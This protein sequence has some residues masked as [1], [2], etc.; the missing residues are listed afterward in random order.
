M[1]QIDL[2]ETLRIFRNMKPGGK[3]ESFHRALRHFL[4]DRVDNKRWIYYPHQESR[5]AAIR[6]EL[7]TQR[8]KYGAEI[9]EDR[10]KAQRP[11]SLMPAIDG[12]FIPDVQPIPITTIAPIPE[13]NQ[14]EPV[15]YE[16]VLCEEV[17][18]SVEKGPN[19]CP[20]CHSHLYRRIL[21]D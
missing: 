14:G 17:W 18:I 4:F 16:C 2:L 6:K 12:N 21:K 1:I 5:I 3:N 13:V 7:T 10:A 15:R 20:E 11:I 19:P 8:A 9:K